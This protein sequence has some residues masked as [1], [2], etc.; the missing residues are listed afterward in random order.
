[1]KYLTLIETL[2]LLHQHQR[3]V[4][5]VEHR[6]ERVEY[7]EV[8]RDDIAVA[9]ALAHEVLGRSL[10]ELAPQTRR[11]LML[12]EEMVSERCERERMA[13]R[14]F[15]FTRREVRERTG[16]SDF[17]IR[18][19][20]D[21]LVSLEYVLAHRGGRGQQFVYELVYDGAGEDGRP[22]LPGLIEVA[23][24]GCA[25]DE[26]NE[27]RGEDFEPPGSENEIASSPHRA[28]IE[29]PLRKGESGAKSNGQKASAASA[30]AEGEKAH[31]EKVPRSYV[32]R[33]RSDTGAE[34]E[35]R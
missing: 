19:H 20:L 11:L 25:Y 34:A 21:K 22:R 14:D 18:T 10:D 2:A 3:A 17:Q 29:P 35:E 23:R 15:R 4:K 27:H 1:M 32:L 24:L 5:T 7:I 26:K 28:P 33:R 30:S 12:V 9:N 13:R 8:T 31:T 16:W 6:G